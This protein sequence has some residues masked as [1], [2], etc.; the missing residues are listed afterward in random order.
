MT[1]IITIGDGTTDGDGIHGA[2]T[3]GTV[4]ITVGAIHGTTT[5]IIMTT[6]TA[7]VLAEVIGTGVRLRG[8]IRIEDL[9]PPVRDRVRVATQVRVRPRGAVALHAIAEQ[10]LAVAR[11]EAVA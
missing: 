6:G 3:L 5:T 8:T 2:M 10:V 4:G 11:L 1:G 7:A 9:R